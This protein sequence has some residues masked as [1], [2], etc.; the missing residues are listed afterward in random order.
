MS[1]RI[2]CSCGKQFGVHD[3][4]AGKKGKCPHCGAPLVLQPPPGYT[5]AP[6]ATKTPRPGAASQAAPPGKPVPR[7]PGH[8]G[9]VRVE[10]SDEEVEIR[11]AA[12]PVVV[13]PTGETKPG[14]PP[15][16][17]EYRHI[18]QRFCHVCGTRYNEGTE[19]CPNC[20][21]PL[22]GPEAEAAALAAKKKPFL[23]WL[24]RAS[25]SKPAFW[26]TVGAATLLVAVAVYFLFFHSAFRRKARL[27]AELTLVERALTSE[28]AAVVSEGEPTIDKLLKLALDMP[29]YPWER[30]ATVKAVGKW[31]R[32]SGGGIFE[33]VGTGEYNL[34]KREL[35]LSVTDG[36]KTYTYQRVLRPMLHVAARTGDTRFLNLMLGQPGYD[37]NEQDVD[38]DTPLH[39]AAAIRGDV[40]EPTKLLL[41][42]EGKDE[43]GRKIKADQNIT[44]KKGLKPV[45]VALAI[46]N[47]K[48]VDTLRKDAA[49]GAAGVIKEWK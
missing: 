36:P 41:K 8:G 19:K 7:K 25:F 49:I 29:G 3:K 45:G 6:E 16:G 15:P 12:A 44:N 23:P 24:P 21:T 2:K 40:V 37:I 17:A 20:W 5:P 43:A 22:S 14:E 9:K 4:Y 18:V 1:F 48:I 46:R 26:A 39:A 42:Y 10:L 27:Q 35:S 38:G 33:T 34:A 13:K 31:E 47:M 32:H 30:P 11:S 28:D